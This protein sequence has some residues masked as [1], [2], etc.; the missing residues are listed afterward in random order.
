MSKPEYNDN[1]ML[2]R[3]LPRKSV[4]L[5]LAGGRGTRLKDLTA[6]RAK[7]AVHFGGKFRIIDFALS[8]CINSGIRRIGVITQ[9]Q[10]HS[11]VQHIQRGWSFLNE[12]MNEFVDLLPA[13]QRVHGESW[14][15][16]TA[17]A[18]T[19]N[20]DIIRRYGAEYVVILAGDH[21]Y[22]Q[23]YSRMLIDHVKKGAR[24]T[25]AC[26]PVPV[27]DASSFGVMA[28]DEND[29]IIDFI[30]KPSDPPTMPGDKT[31]SLASMGIY[32]FDAEYLYQLLDEDG[33]DEQSSHDFGKDIIPAITA[34][35]EARAH[36]FPR[37][38][39]Q[40]DNNAEPYWRD[41]GTLEAYWKANLDLASV[42]PELDVYDRNW[43]I[44]TYVE[45]L[46]SAKF[47]QDRTGSHG[48]TMN[49]LVS[50]GCIISGSVVVHSVL[51]SSVRI[52]SFCNI[53]SAVLLPGVWVGRSCRLRRCVIDRGCVIPE[54]TVIG[55]NAVEDARRFYRSE[56]GTV[57]VTKEM[58]RRPEQ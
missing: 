9:Y 56:E 6:I 2:A 47:V 35:G 10:S 58:L 16:G 39:V 8:N 28:V 3:Q 7:P 25:V 42:V 5:I 40:S 13:Q 45:S 20:L 4:A 22:K 30:E 18:V 26:L 15:R 31:K 44:H 21:I 32:V 41:V 19:Q 43:P 50:G 49:S 38:C 46:P 23:D 14:Y 53:D 12:E 51:F 24:C 1:V 11:L 29:K 57:L 27:E 17:D 33:R 55:E 52:N 48:M 54:G 37:S 34:S 36:P